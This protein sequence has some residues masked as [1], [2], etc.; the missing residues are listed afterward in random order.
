MAEQLQLDRYDKLIL[1]YL[2]QDARM[3]TLE[4]AEKIGLSATPCTR[5]VK[6]LESLG[7]ISRYTAVVNPEALGYGLMVYVGIELDK[8]THDRFDAFEKTVKTMPEV[9]ECSIVTGQKADLLLK[10]LVKDMQHYE[11]FLLGQLTH[12]AGVSGVHTS[13]VLRNIIDSAHLLLE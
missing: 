7:V 9:V 3:S 2:Q 6:R 11:Q 5:R 8:H 10:V 13:F 1:T 4:L 12:L